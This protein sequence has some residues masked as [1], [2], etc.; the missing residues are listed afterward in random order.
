MMAVIQYKGTVRLWEVS[1]RG[2]STRK[3]PTPT[4]TCLI[5]NFVNW[6]Y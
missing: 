2:T 5:R 3:S 1:G 4:K 6:I